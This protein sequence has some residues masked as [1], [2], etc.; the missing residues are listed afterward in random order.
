MKRLLLVLV[1]L[2]AVCSHAYCLSLKW[3]ANPSAD[4]V[5]QYKIYRVHRGGADLVG[6][7]NSPTLTFNVDGSL[8]GNRTVFYIT[9]VNVRGES[10]SSSRVTVQRH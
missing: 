1:F 6:T 9:A 4:G 8:I 3:N 7:V 5:T 10:L 2:L